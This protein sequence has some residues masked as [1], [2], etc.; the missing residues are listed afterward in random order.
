LRE[1]EREKRGEKGKKKERESEKNRKKEKKEER[2]KGREKETQIENPRHIKETK[3]MGFF[4]KIEKIQK[5][6]VNCIF[7]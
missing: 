3:K 5:I 4:K 2:K 7:M 6:E 1:I